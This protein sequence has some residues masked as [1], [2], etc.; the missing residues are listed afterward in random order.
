MRE[1]QES[2]SLSGILA[3]DTSPGL[4][5][6]RHKPAAFGR[7]T[8][9]AVQTRQSILRLSPVPSIYAAPRTSTP[10]P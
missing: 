1:G 10:S 7:Q 5:T 6:K 3:L 9:F 8:L 2:Q 4:G